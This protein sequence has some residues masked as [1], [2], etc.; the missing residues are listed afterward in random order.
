MIFDWPPNLIPEDVNIQPPRKTAGLNV[1][2]S[3]KTQAVPVIHPPFG[4]K[5]TFPKIWGDQVRAWRAMEMLFEGMANTVRVP[6]FDLWFQASDAA[7]GAALTGH[8]DGTGFSDGTLYSTAD[9]VGVTVTGVQGQ[10]TITADFGSYGHILQA[11]D[12][13]GLGEYP[14][15]ARKVSWSGTIATIECARTLI[16]DCDAVPLKLRPTMLAGLTSD[17]GANLELVLA[18]YGQPTLE[19]VERFA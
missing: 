15:G 19:L 16:E 8:S 5:L 13:F 6:L 4:L 2:L 18:R 11:G 17:D 7:I 3:G 10:R 1:S 9:L 12:Y 14:N